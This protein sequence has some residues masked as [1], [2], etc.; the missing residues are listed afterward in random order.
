MVSG[1][2]FPDFRLPPA[3]E[4]AIVVQVERLVVVFVDG[5]FSWGGRW[6]DEKVWLEGPCDVRLRDLFRQFS[7]P[8]LRGQFS[9]GGNS[10]CWY[11]RR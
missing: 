1:T 3:G 2:D 8:G 7:A 11:S 4:H 10:L 6:E 9:E 5:G